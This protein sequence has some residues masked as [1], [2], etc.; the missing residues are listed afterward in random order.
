M[1]VSEA[2]ASHAR[3]LDQICYV[4]RYSGTGVDRE[5]SDTAVHARV[6][7]FTPQDFV[8][9]VVQGDRRVIVLAEDLSSLSP[10]LRS[11]DKFVVGGKEL[12]IIAVDSSTRRVKDVLIAYELQV[13]GG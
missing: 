6:M 8:G 12:A 13:R 2:Q 1:D 9:S 7:N 3:M 11:S 10:P 5:P 4:R